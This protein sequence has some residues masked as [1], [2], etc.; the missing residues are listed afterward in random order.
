MAW[1][2]DDEARHDPG[3]HPWWSE[4]WGFELWDVA[5]LGAYH[6]L[7]LLPNQRRAWYWSAVV[8]PGEPL[9]SLVDQDQVLPVGTLRIRGG[10]VW[11]DVQCEAPFEQWTVLNEVYAVA[12]DDPDEALGRALGVPAPMAFDW[13]WYASGPPGALDEPTL[14]G[15]HQTGHVLGE[16]ELRTGRMAV[17]AA[18]RR[19]HWWGVREW[20]GAGWG[21]AVSGGVRAPVLL[22]GPGGEGMAVERVLGPGGWSEW[23]HPL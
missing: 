3:P 20:F 7:V 2:P 16:I 13:E 9:L 1:R 11:A 10:S 22:R 5:G 4:C 23:A 8:R 21:T 14:E 18:S 19:T 17:D 15:Y 6:V 12:L